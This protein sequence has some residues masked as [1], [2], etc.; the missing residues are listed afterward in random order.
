MATKGSNAKSWSGDL[1]LKP[2]PCY[3]CRNFRGWVRDSA[4]RWAIWC[5]AL[6]PRMNCV[7]RDYEHG[8]WRLEREPGSDDGEPVPA[9]AMTI[10]RLYGRNVPGKKGEWVP[11]Y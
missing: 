7:F 5:S 1:S 2:G 9:A 11:D 6:D 4:T 8:C 10:R 3:T